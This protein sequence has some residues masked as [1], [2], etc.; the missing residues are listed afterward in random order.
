MPLLRSSRPLPRRRKASAGRALGPRGILA[1][2]MGIAAI[3]DL[4]GATVYRNMRGVLPP[5]PPAADDD[6]F[7][8]AMAAIIGAH[9][10]AMVAAGDTRPDSRDMR[11]DSRDMSADSRDAMADSGDAMAHSGATMTDS[12]ETMTDSRDESSAASPV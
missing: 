11:T 9:H 12:R 2:T 6:P 5:P 3:F 1:A 4:T 7:R 10:D 8:A